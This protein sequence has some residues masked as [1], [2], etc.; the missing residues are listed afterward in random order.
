MSLNTSDGHRDKDNHIYQ[1]LYLNY[2]LFIDEVFSQL[3]YQTK[4]S[5]VNYC[6]TAGSFQ[7]RLFCQPD[8]HVFGQKSGHEE[9][10]QT[11]PRKIWPV[12]DKRNISG[13]ISGCCEDADVWAHWSF[14]TL[15]LR[16]W[17]LHKEIFSEVE[18]EVFYLLR[19]NV[20]NVPRSV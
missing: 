6:E 17:T 19:P 8:V 13:E 11:P 1:K 15:L 5:G 18:Q 16:D 20:L 10:L 9:N 4:F 3:Q 7:F 14:W 12:I 2:L